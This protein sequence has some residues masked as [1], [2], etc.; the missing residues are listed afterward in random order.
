VERGFYARVSRLGAQ[1]LELDLHFLS[2]GGGEIALGWWF[3]ECLVPY[4]VNTSKLEAVQSIS[5]V[6]GYGKT[7]SR[8]ARLNDDGMRL[9]VRA[10]L[11]YMNINETPQPNKGRIHINKQELVEEVKKNEGK[12]MFDI[13]GYTRFKEEETTANKF[14]DVTQQVRSRFRPAKP[15]EGPQGT[16]IQDG[17]DA[18]VN[19]LPYQA[20][21][22]GRRDS[23][24][25]SAIRSVGGFEQDRRDSR[26][27]SYNDEDRGPS[28][29]SSEDGPQDRRGG[30]GDRNHNGDQE[31]RGSYVDQDRRG[32]YG[33][34]ERRGSHADQ[35]RRGSY[36][37]R[38]RRGGGG[39]GNNEENRG[40]YGDRDRRNDAD[41]RS[42]RDNDT[43]PPGRDD[44]Q[45][46]RGDAH[47]RDDMPRQPRRHDDRD[48][49]SS[50]TNSERPGRDSYYEYG[51][52]R[53]FDEDAGGRRGSYNDGPSRPPREMAQNDRDRR[54]PD[55]YHDRDN[56]DAGYGG[57]GLPPSDARRAPNHSDRGYGYRHSSDAAM[58]GRRESG[59]DR[60]PLAQDYNRDESSSHGLA[61]V[62]EEM[63]NGDRGGGL[64]GT[65]RGLEGNRG[66]NIE[67]AFSKRRGM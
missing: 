43:R 40:S 7:R 25:V 31:R 16:F 51:D 54:G 22:M 52:D 34:Q 3:E 27:S 26:R 8:G 20:D 6:T 57:G 36:G 48:Q 19:P 2:L 41:R 39:N 65:K 28:R 14:P 59:D 10:M 44:S 45:G 42:S 9:R 29:R 53:R 63:D 35:E 12:I 32:G 67:P 13:A 15:G 50:R 37:E 30:Y 58:P 17:M 46:D 49:R 62:K 47:R 55:R 56:R 60:K 61:S 21:D 66:Y 33:D 5:I 18:P 38:E 11:K 64:A 4:L 23:R 1:W 24:R